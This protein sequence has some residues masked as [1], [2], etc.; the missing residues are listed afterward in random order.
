MIKILFIIG[1][2]SFFGG[3]S[4]FLTS[5]YIQTIFVSSFPYGTFAVNIIGCFL[6]GLL[7]GIS[8]RGNLMNNEWRMFLTIGFCG[9]FTTFST[10]TSENLSLIKDG[11]FFYFALYTGLS[12]FLGLLAT[13]LGNLIIKLF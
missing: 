10:F 3:V 11:D 6:I 7:Y 12:V 9:G 2:G 5:R 13:Y 4:R 1:T 8:E